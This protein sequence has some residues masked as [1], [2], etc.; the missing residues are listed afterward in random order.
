MDCGRWIL[1]RTKITDSGDP[2]RPFAVDGD[3]FVCSSGRRRRPR[4]WAGANMGVQPDFQT[5]A[6]RS[7]DNQKNNCAEL[8]NNGDESFE[9]SDCDKQNGRVCYL[10]RPRL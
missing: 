6:D 10:G 2:E 9:V 8:A 5:A 3:T 1:T 4:K 7:C